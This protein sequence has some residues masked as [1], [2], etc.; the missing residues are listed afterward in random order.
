[1][2]GITNLAIQVK[3]FSTGTDG[4]DTWITSATITGWYTKEDG[5]HGTI[6]DLISSTGPTAWATDGT[7]T[8][9]DIATVTLTDSE[10]NT[11]TAGLNLQITGTAAQLSGASF[12]NFAALSNGDAATGHTKYYEVQV[13]GTKYT[14][15][16]GAENSPTPPS[17]A[18]REV[19]L[20]DYTGALTTD[21]HYTLPPADVI[22]VHDSVP[23]GQHD[24]VPDRSQR[25]RGHGYQHRRHALRGLG[26]EQGPGHGP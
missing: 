21:K 4:T 26:A 24:G 18:A 20:H 15:Y 3:D 10:G 17:G 2:D 16:A 6:S 13:G 22:L 1:L 11:S 9:T 14:L 25:R 12:D 19:T 8:T 7:P 23:C 5:S